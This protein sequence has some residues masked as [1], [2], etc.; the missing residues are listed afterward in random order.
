MKGESMK[1]DKDL[2]KNGM[3]REELAAKHQQLDEMLKVENR[4]KFPDSTQQRR[5]KRLKSMYKIRIDSLQPKA[6]AA[7]DDKPLSN[8]AL[9]S[10]GIDVGDEPDFDEWPE[11][12]DVGGF[13]PPCS[14]PT[15]QPDSLA[16]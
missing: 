12:G 7:G 1:T 5:L 16:A 11:T 9:E 2:P 14:A 10:Q 8:S 6:V 4:K 3:S 13:A 15:R